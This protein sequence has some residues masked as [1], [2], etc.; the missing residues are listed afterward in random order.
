MLTATVKDFFMDFLLIII[1][2]SIHPRIKTTGEVCRS[3]KFEQLGV[4]FNEYIAKPDRNQGEHTAHAIYY[5]NVLRNYTQCHASRKRHCRAF[6]IEQFPSTEQSAL[7]VQ[8]NFLA[9]NKTGD[10]QFAP[11]KHVEANCISPVNEI[12]FY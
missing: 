9:G 8:V 11:T 3:F 12:M 4:W 6:R 7:F 10:M 2:S 5:F 1:P